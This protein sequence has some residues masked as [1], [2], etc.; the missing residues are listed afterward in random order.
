MIIHFHIRGMRE[1]DELRRRVETDLD[2]LNSS[3][4]ITSAHVVLQ[5]Q[6]EVTPPCQAVAMLAGNG[7]GLHAASR[8]HTW[9]IAWQKVL[10]RLQEQIEERQTRPKARGDTHPK[11]RGPLDS[12]RKH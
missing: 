2:G 10:T 11:I 5:F 12:R 8:D 9:A 4:T 1:D 3:M 7:P 6:P